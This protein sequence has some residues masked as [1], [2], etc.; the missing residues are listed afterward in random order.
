LITIPWLFKFW[1]LCYKRILFVLHMKKI[2]VTVELM[3]RSRF[4]G[5]VFPRYFKMLSL[6]F[7]RHVRK[8]EGHAVLTSQWTKVSTYS[9]SH[10]GHWLRCGC[11]TRVLLFTS[12]WW[13]CDSACKPMNPIFFFLVNNYTVDSCLSAPRG[14]K[15]KNI[16]SNGR[17]YKNN[18]DL[19]VE[20][21]FVLALEPGCVWCFRNL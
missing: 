6:Q 18:L 15:R 10:T 2:Y 8:E 17:W 5:I 1:G 12:L 9:R 4:Y 16:I 19:A 11:D 7:S 13:P 3:I 20:H 21:V 14:K